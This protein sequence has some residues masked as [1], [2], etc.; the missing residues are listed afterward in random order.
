MELQLIRNAT[1]KLQFGGVTFLIDPYLGGKYS[2]PSLAGRSKNPTVDLPCSIKE[3]LEGVDYIIVSHLHPDHFDDEA[4]HNLSR[5]APIFCQPQDLD[6]LMSSG[7]G[8]VRAIDRDLDIEGVS[9]TR[10]DCQHG[11]GEI[12]PLMGVASGFVFR[13]LEEKTLYW[14]GDTVWYDGVQDVIDRHKP[15]V[16]VCHAGGNA[17]AHSYNVFGPAFSGDSESLVM[18]AGQVLMLC[19]YA[20]QAQVL[21]THIGALDHDSLTREELR[22]RTITQV[23]RGQLLIPGDGQKMIF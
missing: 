2:Q 12:L 18:D 16:V 5:Q 21:A 9:I 8:N 15:E 11:S 13:H 3:I 23:E 7:F 14:C 19:D 17:F 1:V 10:T 4:Q 6:A 20:T 22:N